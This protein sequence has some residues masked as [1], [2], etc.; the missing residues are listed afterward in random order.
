MTPQLPTPAP[1]G[2][3]KL[4]SDLPAAPYVQRAVVPAPLPAQSRGAT[5]PTGPVRVAGASGTAGLARLNAASRRDAE[6][7][8]LCCCASRR[9]ARR[10]AGHRPYPDVGALLAAADEAA[11]DLGP[12]DLAEALAEERAI[13][14]PPGGGP[15]AHAA[16]RA[17]HAEYER[18]FGRAFV[19][20]LAAVR[21]EDH[22]D[23]ILTDIRSRLGNDGDE[24][25]AIAAGELRALTR[26]RLAALLEPS[27]V[28]APAS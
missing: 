16:L 11:Y 5:V 7:R 22:V 15:A 13:P 14:L 3:S 26:A 21:P 27:T 23:H 4:A 9:W 2:V 24:E 12:G 20:C 8:F 6:A 25:R 10:M 18:R 1:E 28:P 19:I 17:G